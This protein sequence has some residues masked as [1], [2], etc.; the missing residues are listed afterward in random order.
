MRTSIYT[1]DFLETVERW[2]GSMLAPS[3]ENRKRDGLVVF[4]A[5][6][7]ERYF[8]TAHPIFPGA[9]WG[10]VIAGLWYFTARDP[11]F[12]LLISASIFLGGVLLWT[13]IEYLLHRF[14]FHVQP[15]SELPAKITAFVTHGYHHEFPNDRLRLVAPLVLSIP[16]AMPV[17]LLCVLAA[18]RYHGMMLLGGILL[19]YIAYDWVHYY[20]HHFRPTTRLGKYLRRY[21]MEHHYK[22]SGAHFGIS[23]PLWDF[24]FGTARSRGAGASPPPRAAVDPS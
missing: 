12:S 19:G 13:L 22:D 6:W 14:A 11:R 8:A 10:P 18:G 16:I 17:A 9:F 23:S 20:T 15:K 21:H 24:V 5:G 2:D 1:D 3:R 7:F 4:K